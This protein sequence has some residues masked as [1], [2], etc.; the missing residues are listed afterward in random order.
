MVFLDWNSW[1]RNSG[2]TE[3]PELATLLY[4]HCLQI[5]IRLRMITLALHNKKH[6]LQIYL[7]FFPRKIGLW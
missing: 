5:N 2:D 4:A 3:P 1:R 7:L 6:I